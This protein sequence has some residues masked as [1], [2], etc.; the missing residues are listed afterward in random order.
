MNG[1]D[2]LTLE[3]LYALV[4]EH[5]RIHDERWRKMEPLVRAYHD[6]KVINIFLSNVWRGFVAVLG[7]LALLGSLWVIFRK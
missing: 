6:K 5:N 4:V 7:V 1:Q 3:K 2:Q